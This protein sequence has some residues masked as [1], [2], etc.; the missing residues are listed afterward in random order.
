[1]CLYSTCMC[2]RAPA[3]TPAAVIRFKLPHTSCKRQQR[4]A[5]KL[6]Q[7]PPPPPAMQMQSQPVLRSCNSAARWWWSVNSNRASALQAAECAPLSP[8]RA[9]CKAA[10]ATRNHARP[11][12]S[13]SRTAR[14]CAHRAAYAGMCQQRRSQARD[15]RHTARLY[16]VW[17][18]TQSKQGVSPVLSQENYAPR[19]K[20]AC[21]AACRLLQTH[22]QPHAATW[23]FAPWRVKGTVLSP[24][25]ASAP[26]V[27][28]VCCC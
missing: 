7:S 2:A 16:I 20:S 8:V 4:A 27:V 24:P 13:K 14:V 26:S 22:T 25:R 11:L 3:H 12:E 28:G 19:L 6:A 21:K 23:A 5:H 10:Q 15:L 1:M 17:V 18:R 9:T